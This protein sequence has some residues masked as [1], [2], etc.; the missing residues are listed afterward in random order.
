MHQT[1][2]YYLHNT[3]GIPGLIGRSPTHYVNAPVSSLRSRTVVIPNLGGMAGISVNFRNSKVTFGYRGD[4][5]LNAMDT[6]F[7]K[8]KSR[9]VGF[10]GPFVNFSIGIDG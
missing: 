3:Q 7:D 1:S 8:Q 6:G 10:Y 4:F 2:G 5:F 9:T